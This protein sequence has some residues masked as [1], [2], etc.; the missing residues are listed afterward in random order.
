MQAIPA[1]MYHHVSPNPGLVTVS[2][3][4]FEQ[5]MQ[6]LAK[7][8]YTALSADQ[9]LAFIE[10]R[11]QAPRRS[12]LITF[13]DGY[14]DNYVYA[15]PVMQKLGLR[16]VIFAVTGWIGE[17][18]ARAHSG[19]KAADVPPCPS[20][21][22]CKACI[23]QGQADAVMLRWSEIDQMETAGVMEI[24]SHTHTHTRWDKQLPDPVE[25]Q[26]ALRQDLFQSRAE[27]ARRLPGNRPHLCWPQGYFEPGYPDIAAE[28][29]FSALYTVKKGVNV[30]HSS[31]LNIYRIV[32][33]DKPGKWLSRRLAIYS[34]AWLGRLYT[35]LRGE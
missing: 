14:L 6:A 5:H 24:Q 2:P 11:G 15:F 7:G 3:E 30:R 19:M 25:R 18:A 8:G 31:P 34:H 32:T 26:A 29:G 22:E 28:A 1:L 13:D 10:G 33:K 20:H 21:Q 35:G 23:Q 16:G 17:G 27:L 4:H 12:V 9:F